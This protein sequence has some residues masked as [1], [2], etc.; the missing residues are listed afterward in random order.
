MTALDDSP[1]A[2]RN[3]HFV[4]SEEARP[5]R[6]LAEYVSPLEAFPPLLLPGPSEA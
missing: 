1:L 5:L 4:D 6:I 3:A 2:C